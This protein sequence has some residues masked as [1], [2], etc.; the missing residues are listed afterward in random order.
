MQPTAKNRGTSGKTW[1]VVD[2]SYYGGRGAGGI[3]PMT[4]SWS[5]HVCTTV[6]ITLAYCYDVIMMSP[7]K[8]GREGSNTDGRETGESKGIRLITTCQ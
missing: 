8:M 1:E 6:I 7:G 3:R 5:M 4:V 2:A